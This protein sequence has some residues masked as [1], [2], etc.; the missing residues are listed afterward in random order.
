M[1]TSTEI[2]YEM[3]ESIKDWKLF[4]SKYD[5]QRIRVNTP[6]IVMVFCITSIEQKTTKW[7]L[8]FVS[9][10]APISHRRQ[11]W[12]GTSSGSTIKLN[13]GV[14]SV[15]SQQLVKIGL[16]LI[17]TQSFMGKNSSAKNVM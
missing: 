14:T 12:Q 16:K 2:N 13:L 4:A 5:S 3:L 6:N 17:L 7:W 8:S 15:N 11:N 1:D 10:A 9:I